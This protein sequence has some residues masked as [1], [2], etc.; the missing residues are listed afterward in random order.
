VPIA[1][2]R[3][4]AST[5]AWNNSRTESSGCAYCWAWSWDD[6]HGSWPPG[7]R[8]HRTCERPRHSPSARRSGT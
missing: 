7:P 8:T 4:A 3:R 1:C 2:A 5:S 6:A